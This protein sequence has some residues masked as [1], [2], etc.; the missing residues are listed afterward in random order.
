MSICGHE[1]SLPSEAPIFL[2]P[3]S[4]FLSSVEKQAIDLRTAHFSPFQ[5][6]FLF[7]SLVFLV[8]SKH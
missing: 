7:S 4:S 2:I 6:V 3:L 1:F 8:E 5:L